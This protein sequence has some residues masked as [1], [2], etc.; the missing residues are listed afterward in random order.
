MWSSEAWYFRIVELCTRCMFVTQKV[1]RAINDFAFVT[2]DY[3][4]ILSIENHVDRL[5]CHMMSSL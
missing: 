5:V 3:P 2:S 4:L 1:L